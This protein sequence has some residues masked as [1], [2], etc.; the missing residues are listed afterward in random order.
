[1]ERLDYQMKYYPKT[2][3]IKFEVAQNQERWCW[4]DALYDPE[5][6][7]VFRDTRFM[8][9]REANGEKVFWGR[10]N[11]WVV[12]AFAIVKAVQRFQHR[13]KDYGILVV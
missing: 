13:S 7:L 12:G 1:M 6:R 10:G 4:C 3:N 11:G 8:T 2:D 5:E 9:K